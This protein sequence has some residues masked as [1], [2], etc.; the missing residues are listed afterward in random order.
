[1]EEYI[2]NTV[3]RGLALGTPL[4]WAALGEVYAERSGV[5]NLGVEGMMILGAF[6]AFALAQATGHPFLGLLVAAVAGGLAALLHAFVVITLRANQYVSGLALTMFGL[7]LS[8]LLGRRWEGLPLLNTL[9]EV[10]VLTYAVLGLAGVLWLVLYHTRWGI[11]IRSAGEAPAAV[12][13]MGVNIFLVRYLAV[14]F[15]GMLAGVGGGLLSV[16]YRPSWTEGMTVGLGW[17]AIALA[18]FASWDPLRAVVGAFFFGALFHLSFRL[19]TWVAPEPLQMMPFAFTILVL[20]L[21]GRRGGIA[22]Q[23]PP[24]ALGLPY[25]RGEG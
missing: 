9:P 1:M 25:V 3:V 17:I 6:A 15:G 21:A 7:G 19:Q 4:L 23:G 18:I 8:A 13:A 5:V 20:A 12:D 2:L 10:S 22:R 24:E 16:A 14:V 11:I